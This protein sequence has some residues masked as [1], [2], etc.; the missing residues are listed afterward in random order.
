MDS[1]DDDPLREGQQMAGAIEVFET[2]V[3]EA[4][5]E[6]MSVKDG[7]AACDVVAVGLAEVVD[8]LSHADALEFLAP[9][10]PRLKPESADGEQSEPS[11]PVAMVVNDFWYREDTFAPIYYAIA[12][13]FYQRVRP[14]AYPAAPIAVLE[15][16][17]TA[18]FGCRLTDMAFEKNE[19]RERLENPAMLLWAGCAAAAVRFCLQ[20]SIAMP[21][22][23]TLLFDYARRE[24][25]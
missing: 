10:A 15:E 17:D 25:V 4:V 1:D 11:Q 24:A 3:F 23:Y 6:M 8:G 12:R 9:N 22:G 13:D 16:S 20:K 2:V 19:S 21:I 18:L 5:F 7:D 14:A